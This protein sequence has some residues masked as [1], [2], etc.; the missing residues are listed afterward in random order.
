MISILFQARFQAKQLEEKEEKMIQMLEDK[1]VTLVNYQR[2]ACLTC[3]M[4]IVKFNNPFK[5]HS[6]SLQLRNRIR[7]FHVLTTFHSLPA[8]SD[9]SQ[10]IC[11]FQERTIQRVNYG[12]DSANSTNSFSSSAS[13][14]RWILTRELAFKASGEKNK[15][16]EA[17]P[18]V[19]L[20]FLWWTMQRKSWI[21]FI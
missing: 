14:N 11:H 20:H 6:Q 3:S 9:N 4:G 18:M 1:Q 21:Y 2:R 16:S 13:S 12:R 5:S 15:F 8:F 19:L 10:N 7:T 17:S